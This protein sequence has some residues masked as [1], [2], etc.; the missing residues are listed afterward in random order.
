[1]LLDGG[2]KLFSFKRRIDVDLAALLFQCSNAG[3][4]EG[5]CKKDNRRILILSGLG[6]IC[7]SRGCC[8]GH[9]RLQNFRIVLKLHFC[10]SA[11]SA[12]NRVHG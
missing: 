1:M 12:L 11:I 7:G 6:I 2:D 8:G 3:G 9:E 10:C 5:V 4:I